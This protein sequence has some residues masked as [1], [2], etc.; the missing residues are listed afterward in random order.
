MKKQR[1]T[2]AL[3]LEEK[4][5]KALGCIKA[6]YGISSDNQAVILAITLLAKQLEKGEARIPPSP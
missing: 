5:I 3:R 6:H 1:K 2:T 4:D